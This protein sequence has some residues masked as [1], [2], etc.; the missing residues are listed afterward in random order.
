M[1]EQRK[2]ERAIWSNLPKPCM[3]SN[4]WGAGHGLKD[5]EWL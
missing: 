3:H 5:L 1:A 2:R 4:E